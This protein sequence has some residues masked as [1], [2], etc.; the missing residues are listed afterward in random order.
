MASN[1]AALERVFG[2][3]G[4]GHGQPF[5]DLLRDDACWTIIGSTAWSGAYR[6]KEAILKNLLGPLR[7]RLQAPLRTIALRFIAEGDFVAVQGRGENRTREGLAYENSYCWIFEFRDG[8][9]QNIEEYA[10]TELF[11]RVLGTPP[12]ASP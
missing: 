8:A 6:G 4:K 7:S 1:K 12:A 9:I 10:D 11:S 3:T 5:L 2:A